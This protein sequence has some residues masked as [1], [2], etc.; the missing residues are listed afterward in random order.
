MGYLIEAMNAM[1]KNPRIPLIRLGEREDRKSVCLHDSICLARF[2]YELD[3]VI[4]ADGSVIWEIKGTT[5]TIN[6]TSTEMSSGDERT[7]WNLA[8]LN[9]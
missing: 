1:V 2:P 9:D 6:G 5:P 4:D 8:L 3:D 7:Q